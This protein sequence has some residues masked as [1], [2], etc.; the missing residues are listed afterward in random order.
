[1]NNIGIGYGMLRA[2]DGKEFLSYSYATLN[3]L[4]VTK[5]FFPLAF[6]FHFGKLVG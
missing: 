3:C 4:G 2:K 5:I 6:S 1:M